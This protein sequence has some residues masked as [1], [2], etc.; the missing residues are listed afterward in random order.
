MPDTGDYSPWIDAHRGLTEATRPL[1]PLHLREEADPALG[2][3]RRTVLIRDANQEWGWVCVRRGSAAL[4]RARERPS[5]HLDVSCYS[6]RKARLGDSVWKSSVPKK[7]VKDTGNTATEKKRA[8]H[9]PGMCLLE[10]GRGEGPAAGMEKRCLREGRVAGKCHGCTG[11][12]GTRR[13]REEGWVRGSHGDEGHT[14]EVSRGFG[15]MVVLGDL[16]KSQMEV[17]EV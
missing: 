4:C 6:G 10:P 13:R 14:R 8:E 15:N 17:T 2:E 16:D 7:T 12:R 1:P 5:Q 11:G 9:K 3:W